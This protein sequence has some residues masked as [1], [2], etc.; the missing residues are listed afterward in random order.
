[1]K[2]EITDQCPRCGDEF[3][4]EIVGTPEQIV[5]AMRGRY[6]FYGIDKDVGICNDCKRYYKRLCADAKNFKTDAA[7]KKYIE[8]HWQAVKT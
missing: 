2:A 5:K 8:K 7:R 3:V 1:M 4:T 6:L